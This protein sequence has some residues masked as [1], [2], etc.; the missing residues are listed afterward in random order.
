VLGACTF[1]QTIS[2]AK[3]PSPENPFIYEEPWL[4]TMSRSPQFLL[5]SW[6][7]WLFLI[8]EDGNELL[9]W[10]SRSMQTTWNQIPEGNLCGWKS[11]SATCEYGKDWR[12]R[13][14]YWRQRRIM[15]RT[16]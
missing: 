11:Q 3:I 10:T 4:T 1:P 16:E 6:Y 9:I 15:D 7:L 8:G 14:I 13:M 5:V 2:V 12:M